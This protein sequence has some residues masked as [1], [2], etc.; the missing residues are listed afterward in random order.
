[1]PVK[2]IGSDYSYNMWDNIAMYR[3]VEPILMDLAMRPEFM[4]ETAKRF[5]EIAAAEV[6]QCLEQDLLGT[7]NM[8]IHCTAAPVKDLPGPEYDGK[9]TEKEIWGRCSAQIFGAVS[10][11]MHDEFDLAYNEKVFGEFGLLYYGCCE[12]MHNKVDI[13]RKRFKNLRKISITPWADPE[14]AADNIGKDF[15]FAA[16]PNPA[17]VSM[18]NFNPEPVKEE[19]AAYLE[20]CKRN[21]TTCEFVLKDISTISNNPDTL[22]KWAETVNDVVDRYYE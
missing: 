2:I 22:T 19:I 11:D 13:L 12:P 17:N 8:L 3:G 14:V 7:G 9:I 5:M 18:P 21:G 10:P 16:K 20:P 6:K 1:M 15:V 4:H